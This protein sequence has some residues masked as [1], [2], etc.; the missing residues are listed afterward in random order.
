MITTKSREGLCWVSFTH[1]HTILGICTYMLNSITHAYIT[2]QEERDFHFDKEEDN[3]KFY[4]EN[5][6][7]I[8]SSVLIV[9]YSVELIACLLS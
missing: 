2:I 3:P 9:S 5:G 4:E 7:D 6:Y 1:V 8:D